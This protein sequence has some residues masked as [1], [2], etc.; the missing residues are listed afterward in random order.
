MVYQ[1]TEYPT[2]HLYFLGIDTHLKA[3]VYNK[4]IQVTCRIFYGISGRAFL[5]CMAGIRRGGKGER[6]ASEA[7]EDRTRE[8][9]GRERLQGCYCFLH[10]AL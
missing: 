7:R 9:R 4:K 10:S 2:R 3:C 8:D 5:A 6:R 1:A